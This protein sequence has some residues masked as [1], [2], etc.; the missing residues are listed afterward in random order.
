MEAAYGCRLGLVSYTAPG[1]QKLGCQKDRNRCDEEPRSMRVVTDGLGPAPRKPSVVV[2]SENVQP[3]M[4]KDKPTTENLNFQSNTP[5]D[6]LLNLQ[7]GSLEPAL[8]RSEWGESTDDFRMKVL[9]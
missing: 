9:S 4:I 8:T 1:D 3:M 5:R 2:D 7:F 6:K